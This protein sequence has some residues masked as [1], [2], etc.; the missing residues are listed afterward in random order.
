M[1]GICTV[2]LI[3]DF[4]LFI[5]QLVIYFRYNEYFYRTERC[6]DTVLTKSKYH[7]RVQVMFW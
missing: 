5:H 1:Y 6:P 3:L 2:K 7:F 4:S